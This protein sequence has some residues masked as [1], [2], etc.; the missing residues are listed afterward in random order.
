VHN[1]RLLP[2]PGRL[3]FAPIE[4]QTCWNSNEVIFIRDYFNFKAAVQ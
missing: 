3:I 2:G 4:N 1:Y